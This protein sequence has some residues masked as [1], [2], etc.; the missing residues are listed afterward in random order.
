MLVLSDDVNV[1]SLLSFSGEKF[2]VTP[3]NCILNSVVGNIERHNPVD[4]RLLVLIAQQGRVNARLR[5]RSQECVH[6]GQKLGTAGASV[7]GEDRLAL[8]KTGCEYQGYG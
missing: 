4:A 8:E 5:S 3:G 7:A 1:L 2:S 6:L